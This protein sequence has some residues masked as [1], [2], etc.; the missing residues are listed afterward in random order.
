MKVIDKLYQ[1]RSIEYTT[2]PMRTNSL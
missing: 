1:E 2:Q